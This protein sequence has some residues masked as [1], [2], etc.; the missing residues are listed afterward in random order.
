[1][2]CDFMFYDS[3]EAMKP[4]TALRELHFA[5]EVNFS[6]W[7]SIVEGASHAA[8]LIGNVRF[9]DMKTGLMLTGPR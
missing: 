7:G 6:I 2:Y 9:I 5:M 4:F 8:C 1:M 3:A